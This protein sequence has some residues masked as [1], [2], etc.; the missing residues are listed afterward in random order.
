MSQ[1]KSHISI[2]GKAGALVAWAFV[3]TFAL[4]PL[5][6]CAVWTGSAF[7]SSDEIA[8]NRTIVGQLPPP[9][10]PIGGGSTSSHAAVTQFIPV[11]I[12]TEKYEPSND[13]KVGPHDVLFISVNGQSE[14]SSTPAATGMR[15]IGS[16]VDGQGHVQL[17]LIG[18]FKVGGLTTGQIQIALR[19]HYEQ[20]L[21]TPW[22]VVEI[23]EYRSQPIY[24]IGEFREPTTYYMD[25]PMR[26]AQAISL[27]GGITN[28]ADMR[29]AR[30]LRDGRVVAVDIYRLLY[31]GDMSQ[32]SWIRPS[33]TLFVPSNIDQRVFVLGDVARPGPVPIIHGDMNL[34]EAFARVGDINRVGTERKYVRVIRSLS[35]TRGELMVIDYDKIIRGEAMDFP[36]QSGDIVYVPRTGLGKWNDTL[37]EILPTL[38]TVST[39]IQPFVLLSS[40]NDDN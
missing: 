35:P 4:A 25:R 33:D 30:L 37:K 39:V 3:L 12:P 11:T 5:A 38:Q 18:Q 16:R 14:L 40:T 2:P 1:S 7:R 10:K 23:L 9:G 22:V 19:K 17:P 32:N 28:I 20:H 21:R 8:E 26:V 24:L 36:L 29:S 31:E 34:T 13:Y 15:A 27:A 6:G